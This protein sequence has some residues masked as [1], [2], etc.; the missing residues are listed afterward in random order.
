MTLAQRYDWSGTPLKAGLSP[1]AAHCAELRSFRRGCRALRSVEH[2]VRKERS[3]TERFFLA[4]GKA[5]ARL[6]CWQR[7]VTVATSMARLWQSSAGLFVRPLAFLWHCAADCL[8]K[9]C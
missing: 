1:A 7:S 9:K 8:T 5:L 6:F 3:T 4:L 2:N